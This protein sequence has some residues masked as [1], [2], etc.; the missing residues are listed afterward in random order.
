M[1]VNGNIYMAVVFVRI[2]PERR[3]TKLLGSPLFW[4][5]VNYPVIMP[6]H[7]LARNT[8]GKFVIE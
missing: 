4:N 5:K 3:K 8:F 6:H 2:N 7:V 1:A